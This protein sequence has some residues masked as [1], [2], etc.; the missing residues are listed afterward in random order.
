MQVK[1]LTLP[2][3]LM[4]VGYFILM[5]G[6][7]MYFYRHMRGMKDYFTGHNR[8]PWWLSGVSFY[9]SSFSVAAFVFYPGLAYR[10]GWVGITLLW[11]A[12][13][14]TLFSA[15]LFGIR[16]R[17]ARIESPTEYLETRY[18]PLLRQLF[19]WQ[20][21]PVKIIDDS[22]KLF[23]TGNFISVCAGI[24][25]KWSI[26]GTGGIM[27]LY[28]F[29]GGLWAVMVTDFVQFV[30]LTAAILIILPL[31]ILKA[32]GAAAILHN[33]SPDFFKLTSAE[34]GWSYI[35]PVIF[36][37]CLSWSCNNWSL[38]QRYY[39]VPKEKDVIKTG[40]SVVAL[41]I[42]G[43]PLMFFPAIAAVQFIPQLADAGKVYPTLCAMLLPAGMLGLAIAAMF[44]ATM[45]TLSGDY[46]VCA[47]VLTNDVYRRL[48]RP[49]A[50]Q[51]ELVFAGR[52][53]TIL[54]GII[55]LVVATLIANFNKA[56]DLF[57]IMLTLFGVATAPVAVPMLLGLLSRRFNSASAITGFL[58]G[59]AAGLVLFFVSLSKAPVTLPGF[60]WDPAT[61][62]ATLFSFSQ[63]M[64]I[65]LFITTCV[66]TFLAMVVASLVTQTNDAK[67]KAVDG[68]LNRLK[69]PIGALPED[70]LPSP[71][72]TAASP[73]R[74]VGVCIAAI[75]VVMFA[76]LPWAR[77]SAALPLNLGLSCALLLVGVAMAWPR[78]PRHAEEQDKAA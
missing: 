7:G 61:S 55:A 25:I 66:V 5:L 9:M 54:I 59:T 62:R 18:S 71:M 31:S 56:E 78:K 14:A 6:I 60:A 76:V 4:L 58:C 53:A 57:K 15:L 48:L 3:H 8:I 42:I 77:G 37:Y 65:I 28:T 70:T 17:R 1:G 16:W 20:G 41:Y 34:F 33:T 43:P 38:I 74:V 12:V 52:I 40:M 44:A 19:A 22:I 24:D 23:A 69:T 72:D 73:F 47:S 35:I 67:K 29:M 46:N 63:D 45:S 49:H 39:C 75:A 11:V 26:L 50:G 21:V 32:G 27:L 36:L 13:P 2:D 10:H 30:V 68:F 51:R 64:E